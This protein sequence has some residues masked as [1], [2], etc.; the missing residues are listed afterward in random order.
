M[1]ATPDQVTG[2]HRLVYQAADFL[3]REWEATR[4]N[5]ELC[6][7]SSLLDRK[8][9][10][11]DV[12][13]R[14]HRTINDRVEGDLIL[15]GATPNK[16]GTNVEPPLPQGWNII[17]FGLWGDRQFGHENG[18]MLGLRHI[19]KAVQTTGIYANSE[20]MRRICPDMAPRIAHINSIFRPLP[21]VVESQ[22]GF[23]KASAAFSREDSNLEPVPLRRS[24]A[25]DG[26]AALDATG[27][28]DTRSVE[29]HTGKQVI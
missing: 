20:P 11:R 5:I 14:F 29:A 17:D 1:Q 26:S 15:L 8:F 23:Y 9:I 12:L 6:L 16:K 2:A 22:N 19:I 24:V 13:T 27:R 25:V 3:H 10:A 7:D 18:I 4:G 21:D 28:T